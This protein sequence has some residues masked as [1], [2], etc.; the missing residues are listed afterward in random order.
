MFYRSKTDIFS[1][2]TIFLMVWI[3]AAV[4]LLPIIATLSMVIIVSAIFIISSVFIWWYATSIKFD[5][6]KNYLLVKGG[7]FKSKIPYKSIL[8]VTPTTERLTGYRISSSDKGLEIVY[9]QE[10]HRSIKILPIEKMMFIT[11]LKKRCPNVQIPENQQF[12]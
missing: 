11:E 6:D 7:P 12:E 9:N 10:A 3:G 5:F 1:I 4:S 2:V 8:T